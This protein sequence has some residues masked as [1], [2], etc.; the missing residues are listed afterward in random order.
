MLNRS[1]PPF[2]YDLLKFNIFFPSI[3]VDRA[4]SVLAWLLVIT[5]ATQSLKILNK[6]HS[7][8]AVLLQNGI[9]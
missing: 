4:Q 1:P 5:A 6:I 9:I 2:W 8:N 3:S 7:F